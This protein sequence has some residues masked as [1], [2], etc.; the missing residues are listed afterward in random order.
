MSDEQIRELIR[1]AQA[2]PSNLQLLRR[3]SSLQTRAASQLPTR[4]EVFERL[5]SFSQSSEAWPVDIFEAEL[6]KYRLQFGVKSNLNSSRM[7]TLIQSVFMGKDNRG[8]DIKDDIDDWKFTLKYTLAA[9]VGRLFAHHHGWT[10][11]GVIADSLAPRNIHR[12]GKTLYFESKYWGQAFKAWGRRHGGNIKVS[13]KH[14][15]DL[16]SQ[17]EPGHRLLSWIV[18]FAAS[19]SGGSKEVDA[20]TLHPWSTRAYDEFTKTGGGILIPND[21]VPE[22]A[23]ELHKIVKKKYTAQPS[24]QGIAWIEAGKPG[25]KKAAKKTATRPSR[26][27]PGT[28]AP[29]PSSSEDVF[30]PQPSMGG[31]ILIHHSAEHGTII[32]GDTRTYKDQIKGITSPKFRW[33]RK[34]GAWYVGRSRGVEGDAGYNW[35]EL[36]RVFQDAGARVELEYPG[37]EGVFATAQA[38]VSDP[39]ESSRSAAMFGRLQTMRGYKIN[40]LKRVYDSLEVGDI[41]ATKGID[42]VRFEPWQVIKKAPKAR[43]DHTFELLRTGRENLKGTKR[44]LP[45]TAFEHVVSSAQKFKPGTEHIITA[46]GADIPPAGAPERS[47]N[48]VLDD[49]AFRQAR[50][51]RRSLNVKGWAEMGRYTLKIIP[52]MNVEHDAFTIQIEI[53]G[54]VAGNEPGTRRIQT[55][56]EFTDLSAAQDRVVELL[57]DS[58][59][60]EELIRKT[61]EPIAP[62]FMMS[63]TE[64]S[65]RAMRRDGQ[66]AP[67]AAK[68]A[69]YQAVADRL[70]LVGQVHDGPD[71][72]G[73]GVQKLIRLHGGEVVALGKHPKRIMKGLESLAREVPLSIEPAPAPHKPEDR[74]YRLTKKNEW[75][76]RGFASE[77]SNP[78]P[79]KTKREALAW[80]E[81]NEAAVRARELFGPDPDAVETAVKLKL[82]GKPLRKPTMEKLSKAVDKFNKTPPGGW[83]DSDRLAP[84]PAPKPA[85]TPA[86]VID[87][88]A[89]LIFRARRPDEDYIAYD[90]ASKKWGRAARDSIKNQLS[91]YPPTTKRLGFLV[92]AMVKEKLAPIDAVR[93]VSEADF[94]HEQKHVENWS[95][96]YEKGARDIRL[97]KTPDTPEPARAQSLKGYDELVLGDI[98][99]MEPGRLGYVMGFTRGSYK[100]KPSPRV[101]E[102]M[103]EQ[104]GRFSPKPPILTRKKFRNV[105]SQDQAG[106]AKNAEKPPFM[107]DNGTRYAIEI[108]RGDAAK[109]GREF[110]P[111]PAEKPVIKPPTNALFSDPAQRA[112]GVKG[113]DG[114]VAAWQEDP[115]PAELEA[116][117]CHFPAPGRKKAKTPPPSY[118]ASDAALIG[119]TKDKHDKAMPAADLYTKS[120]TF[121]LRRAYVEAK[122]RKW[123]IL[124]AEYGLIDRPFRTIIPPYDRA[125]KDLAKDA[126][127]LAY[128][129]KRVSRQLGGWLK[130][131]G[132]ALVV[133]VHAGQDYL[134]ALKPLEKEHSV[135]FFSPFTG[136]G[137]GQVEQ[138]TWYREQLKE[139]GSPIP[140][141][142]TWPTSTA[143]AKT[144]PAPVVYD[145]DYDAAQEV[146]QAFVNFGAARQAGLWKLLGESKGSAKSVRAIG[147]IY[148]PRAKINEL[149]IAAKGSD[150][151]IKRLDARHGRPKSIPRMAAALDDDWVAYQLPQ[152]TA[153]WAAIKAALLDESQWS[154]LAPKKATASQQRKLKRAKRPDQAQKWMLSPK[155]TW[156]HDIS[157]K[158][159]RLKAE[160]AIKSLQKRIKAAKSEAKKADLGEAITANR[161]IVD[162]Y[163]VYL[164]PNKTPVDVASWAAH[165]KGARPSKRATYQPML[166]SGNRPRV[167]RG[168]DRFV[169]S[170]LASA[171]ALGVLTD[172]SVLNK[173]KARE[174]PPPPI[175]KEEAKQPLVKR[176]ACNASEPGGNIPPWARNQCLGLLYDSEGRRYTYEIDVLPIEQIIT[177]HDDQFM[178]VALFPQELQARDRSSVENQLEV[179]KIARELDAERLLQVGPTATE[180]TPIIW[181]APLPG[182]GKGMVALAGNGRTMAFRQAPAEIQA[183][184]LDLVHYLTGRRG[185]L[186]RRIMRVDKQGA[187]KFAAA[188]QESAGAAQTPLEKSRG[189]SRSI[190]IKTFAELPHIDTSHLRGSPL[191]DEEKRFSKFEVANKSLRARAFPTGE[192]AQWRARAERYALI[193]LSLLPEDAKNAIEDMGPAAE[194]VLVGMSPYLGEMGSRWAKGDFSQVGPY[195]NVT[196]SLQRIAPLMSK[197]KGWSPSRV[198]ADLSQRF[199]QPTLKGFEEADPLA[200]LDFVD[201]AWLLG[202]LRAAATTNPEKR[203]AALGYK[204]V[205]AAEEELIDIQQAMFGFE[206]DVRKFISRVFASKKGADAKVAKESEELMAIIEDAMRHRAKKNPC[207]PCLAF[208]P[209]RAKV[210]KAGLS[211][212]RLLASRGRTDSDERTGLRRSTIA[213]LEKLEL[214]EFGYGTYGEFWEAIITDKGRAFLGEPRQNPI[215]MVGNPGPRRPGRDSR[216]DPEDIG[217]QISFYVSKSR[218]E[219]LPAVAQDLHGLIYRQAASLGDGTAKSYLLMAADSLGDQDVFDIGDGPPD[220]SLTSQAHFDAAAGL[221]NS[222]MALEDDARIE[223]VL[224]LVLA[225]AGPYKRKMLDKNRA[226][227]KAQAAKNKRWQRR[228]PLSKKKGYR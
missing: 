59:K 193:F 52:V 109:R 131:E 110:A 206:P 7:A 45:R 177:S 18:P 213:A 60:L 175:L 23:F 203:G 200:G 64:G 221:L 129:R 73:G 22:I 79:F 134:K 118:F 78:T 225:F 2:D 122:E 53:A 137:Y 184:Y 201:V 27:R 145:N 87:P 214:A 159:A 116:A 15:L 153:T 41:W 31:D 171:L 128:W 111:K 51:I 42:I 150:A 32:T 21:F 68:P 100:A 141:S 224:S 11:S 197:Y 151:L 95:E 113:Y 182:G 66:A 211:A 40:D 104:W 205:K 16:V 220:F 4:Q 155:R 62:E 147:V 173:M 85:K 98:V 204:L 187:L 174:T 49:S 202:I 207:L 74:V 105:A 50:K 65:E 170:Q 163:N 43:G 192:A 29:A 168:D 13:T 165:R 82:A 26:P 39:G 125:M 83:D 10:Y 106:K 92:T 8:W 140:T 199:S 17:S 67:F 142:A 108:G 183:K 81:R 97:S 198:F 176:Y 24:V 34:L 63:A 228:N 169:V 181:A 189:L 115:S 135:I 124:S 69:S 190:G 217:K 3:L 114:P 9:L 76:V 158:R 58:D 157:A 127:E 84:T 71:M 44:L 216:L 160:R 152:P 1:R 61:P 215:L 196:P 112:F 101:A 57:T 212:L 14:H 70:G 36:G 191:G 19:P 30:L 180:G 161:A 195:L 28:P 119:C 194:A 179:K 99:L 210:S 156:A 102:W 185:V 89:P 54:Y 208:N 12:D 138:E 121:R 38:P 77:K 72:L 132:R 75:W 219:G 46:S 209:K 218:A 136:T 167:Q 94:Q 222:A 123:G 223:R 35:P 103:G 120:R 96:A 146:A 178:P 6:R 5:L 172:Y 166:P 226:I 139:M 188:S 130:P 227:I 86:I 48:R 144:A 107:R 162:A 25:E 91:P 149:V 186:V 117:R 37:V 164:D 80:A 154:K 20:R 143:P 56:E 33:S 93:V 88:S 90:K 126:D 55:R 148:N 133:E 47:A